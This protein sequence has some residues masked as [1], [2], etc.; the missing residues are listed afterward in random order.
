MISKSELIYN[1]KGKN[2]RDS[3]EILGMSLFITNALVL[4]IVLRNIL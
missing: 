4:E 1:K 2:Q 3:V